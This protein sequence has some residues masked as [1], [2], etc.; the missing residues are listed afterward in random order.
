MA[1]V[2][3]LP[4]RQNKLPC[5]TSFKRLL[6][7]S[8]N[9]N[10]PE[11]SEARSNNIRFLTYIKSNPPPDDPAMKSFY[12]YV[13]KAPD[14][15]A[16]PDPRVLAVYLYLKLDHQQTKGFQLYMIMYKEHPNNQLPKDLRNPTAFLDAINAIVHLQNSDPNYRY[17]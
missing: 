7:M 11:T 15:P 6:R 5:V 8:Q 2:D 9:N 10:P 14:F 1:T 16:S 4:S 3:S 13:E 17:S 12:T